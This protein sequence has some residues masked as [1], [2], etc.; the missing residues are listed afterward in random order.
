MDLAVEQT[1]HRGHALGGHEQAGR[2]DGKPDEPRG[3]ERIHDR[4]LGRKRAVAVAGTEAPVTGKPVCSAR[5]LDLLVHLLDGGFYIGRACGVEHGSLQGLLGSRGTQAT[6]G[7]HAEGACHER[8][9]AGVFE[10]SIDVATA[11]LNVGANQTDAR[12]SLLVHARGIDGKHAPHAAGLN[13]Q[14]KALDHKLN[15]S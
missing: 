4:A 6:L 7:V 2:R 15:T 8:G 11:Q 9:K 1:D 10:M 3:V 14:L 13:V 12:L 5:S